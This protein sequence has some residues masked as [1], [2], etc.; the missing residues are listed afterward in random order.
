MLKLALPGGDLRS[1]TAERLA[2]VGLPSS[3]YAD[4]SRSLRVAIDGRDDLIARVFRERDIPIQVAQGA[5]HLAVCGTPSLEEFLARHPHEGLVPLRPLDFGRV[6][7]VL[8]AP[9]AT[10]ERLGPFEDWTRWSGIRVATEFPFLA[11][12]LVRRA[13]LPR[14]RV[15]ALWGAAEGY[16]PEDAEACLIALSDDE[17]LRRHGLTVVATVVEGPAWLVAGRTALAERDLGSLLQPLQRLPVSPVGEQPQPPRTRPAASV[18]PAPPPHGDAVRLALPDGHGQPHTFRALADA[19]LSFDGYGETAAVRRP[20]SGIPGLELKVVRP[21]DMPALVAQGNFDLA[22]T[23]RDLLLDHRHAFPSTPVVEVADLHRSRY[24]LAAVI[25]EDIPGETIA[26]AVAE[27]R[28]RGRAVIRVAAELPHLA[29]HYARA[30]QLGR[31]TVMPVA[32]ASEGFVPEDAEILIEGT[33]TGR[34]LIAN[35]LRVID[36]I[37]VSTNC[38]IAREDWA[39]SPRSGLIGQL[40]EQLRRVPAPA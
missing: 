15:L 38:L 40:I 13:R 23:G 8:A 36:Q 7:V 16:P 1:A 27:W 33:E 30:A 22:V 11:E 9:H 17:P 35:R 3:A 18:S 19:G 32:G 20:E 29:D 34:S 21:Q 12:R 14:A 24:T 6:R 28:R 31:Y 25:S 37:G 4:G 39:L 2:A 10:V 5:Y 26:E